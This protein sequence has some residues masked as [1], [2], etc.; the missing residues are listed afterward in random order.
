M[1]STHEKCFYALVVSMALIC[2]VVIHGNVT[3]T[4]VVLDVFGQFLVVPVLGRDTAQLLAR[5][6]IS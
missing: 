3:P 4:S 6:E 2:I 5:A 1:S